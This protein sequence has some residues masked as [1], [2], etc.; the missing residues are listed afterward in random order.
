MAREFTDISDLLGKVNNLDA[1]TEIE[2]AGVPSEEVLTAE[3]F[4]SLV[5][6]LKE[7]QQEDANNVKSITYN[8]VLYEPDSEGNVS[9]N[10]MLNQDTYAVRLASDTDTDDNYIIKTGDDFNIALRYMAI[11]IT[12]AGDRLNYQSVAGTLTVES[13]TNGTDYT[14]LYTENGLVSQSEN[15]E[16]FPKA[17]NLGNYVQ[18]GNQTIKVKVS[19]YYLDENNVRHD[20][21]G[22]LFF[23]INAVNL[24][25]KNMSSWE[26][27]IL[28]SNEA[29]PLSMSF[30][31]AV[32]K[33]LHVNISGS[34]GTYK[35]VRRFGADVQRT[36]SNPYTWT[37]REQPTIGILSH[38]VHTVTAWLSC[39]DGS[40]S[41]DS[42]GYVNGIES[43][44][45]VNRF[46]VVNTSAQDQ[47]LYKPYLLLQQVVSTAK[48]Y[49]RTVL[50]EYAVW[51]PST[52]N[53]E[54]ASTER[55]PISIRITDSADNDTD[56]TQE[57]FRYETQVDSSTRYYLDTTVEIEGTTEGQAPDSYDAYLRV[58][59]Y[60]TDDSVINFMQES[61]GTRYYLIEI[62]NSDD[63]SPAAGAHFFL[64]PKVRN[65]S[66]TNWKRIINQASGQEVSSVWSE[67][68]R[69]VNDGWVED[70]DG[71]KVLRVLAGESLQ[72]G[73]EPW[74]QFKTTA[75][76][77]MSLEITFAVRNITNEEEPIFDICQTIGQAGQLL[78]LR[79]KPLTAFL[80]AQQRQAEN[81]QDWGF[82]EDVRT[83]VM[84]VLNPSVIA[85]SD[86]ELTW[87]NQNGPMS[88][89][90]LAKI[91]INGYVNREI[92]YPLNVGNW[93]QGEGHGGIKI[94][95]EHADIDIYGIRCYRG[96][97]L[98]AQTVVNQNFVAS[99]P[100]AEEKVYVRWANDILDGNGRIS[101]DKVKGKGKRCL[102]LFGTDN[103]KLNQDTKNGY[104]C[105]W[106]IDYYDANGNYIPELSGTICKSAYEAYL[107]GTLNGKKCLM[108]TAQGST[109]NTYWDNNEQTKLDKVTF[110]ISVLFINLHA[111][112]GW[113]ASMST[114][115]S[116]GNCDN[117]IYLDGEQITPSEYEGLTSAQKSRV[118]IDVLDGWIDGNGM[119]HGQ[120][121]TSA[122]G[123]AKAT[124]LVNKINYASPMQ[125]HK[126]GATRL[127]NDVMMAVTGGMALHSQD[128]KAR[129]S[130]LEDSFFFFTANPN[131][132]HKI[133]YRGL[134]TFGSGKADKPTW[135]YN[136]NK[137]AFMFEGANNNLPLCDFR[138]PAD[139][140]VVYVP[141]EEAW[142]Y[143]GDESFDYDLGKT[144]EVEENGETVEYPIAA[145]DRIFRR[146]V[147]F[148]YTHG[149]SIEMF[150]GSHAE[151]NAHFQALKDSTNPT[152]PSY[153]PTAADA[154]ATMKMKKYWFRDGGDKFH[155]VRFNFVTDSWVDAGRYDSSE[156][157]LY[158]AGVLDLSTDAMTKDAYDEWI[159]S[160]YNGDYVVLNTMFI[161]AIAKHANDNF[162]LVGHAKAHKTNYNVVNFLLAGTDNCSKNLYFH[163]DPNTGLVWFDGDDLDS[164]FKTDNNG[165]QTKVY[166]L[167]RIHDM[168]DYAHGYKRQIDYEGRNSN[169]FN[170]IEVMWEEMSDELRIN[171]RE[172]LTAMA[173]LVSD[174]DNFEV[175]GEK[176]SVW[177]CLHKYFF[178]I[179]RYFPQ[180]AYNEQARLRYEYPKSFGYVSQGNQA[181]GVDPITQSVGNQLES[182]TQYMKR[183]L[184]LVAS[185]ACWGD[186]SSGVNS[187]VVGLSDSGASFSVTPGSGRIG[188]DYEF[189]VVPH[190]FIYPTG[191][192]DRSAIDPHVR[193]APGE[194]YSIMVAE[195][196][197]ISGDSSVGL[198]ATN[199]YRS[200]G[201][202]GNMVV[203]NNSLS[204]KGRR[205]TEFIAEPISGNEASF[206]PLALSLSDA[207]N[208]VN[209]SLKGCAQLGG[210]MDFSRQTRLGS[211][212]LRG[213]A[214]DN[215]SL[216]QTSELESIK[217]G[218]EMANINID[219][220]PQLSELT[221]ESAANLNTLRVTDSPNVDTLS[222]V[223]M[224][225]NEDGELA[226][227]TINNINWSNVSPELLTWIANIPTTRLSGTMAVT[228]GQN[229]NSV[230]KA[231][232]I[233]KFGEIDSQEN[234]LYITYTQ[235]NATS[236]GIT[237][238]T[239]I[240]RSTGDYQFEYA[241]LPQAANNFR[242]AE[243]SVSSNTVGATIDA[244]TGVLHV[245]QLGSESEDTKVTVTLALT[246]LSGET[247]SASST[248]KLY[249]RL[250]K[251][252]DFAYADGQFDAELYFGKNV[253]GMVYK[254]TDY[255]NLTAA[256]RTRHFEEHPEWQTAYE[257]GQKLY[258][259][260][261]EYKENVSYKTS[262]EATT[263][264]ST[265]WGV[266][267][268]NANGL[269]EAERASIATAVTN[270]GS[271]MTT[272]QVSDIPTIVNNSTQGLPNQAGTGTE[273]Y[274]RD[275]S[276]Y[277]DNQND[278][279]KVYPS[280]SAPAD[281]N[282][283]QKTKLIVEHANK[284]ISAY[285]GDMVDGNG[286]TI[287]QELGNPDHIIP[288][289][290]TELA[291]LLVAL[292]NIGG[293]TQW[294]QVAYPAAYSCFLMEPDADDLHN[295]Y[296]RG[297]WYLPGA[298]DKVRLYIFF[299]NSRALT[300][301]DSG[302]PTADY[303][304]ENNV[305][306]EPEPTEARKP[307]Y[308]NVLK[309]AADKGLTCPI[310][311]PSLSGSWSSSEYDSTA[312]WAVNFND[313]GVFSGGAL[314]N[315][316]SFSYVVRPVAEF[317]FEL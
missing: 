149:T 96:I 136:T 288:Q 70:S 235:R 225:V 286:R 240:I 250:P 4:V 231:L 221:I 227:V 91:Y 55:L 269:T 32:E 285:V 175:D 290:N 7:L 134:S 100:S 315:Y 93:I 192:A 253:V 303:S 246:L 180:V 193:V 205:L 307:I 273:N 87:Q 316:K 298:A 51:I 48:N 37:E 109:A 201:N 144:V 266:F 183:R 42:D 213:T 191:M 120:C 211:L 8:N 99:L 15:S 6:A 122:I 208:M 295:Q 226:S 210:T 10:Q 142:C 214:I 159:D 187:G 282:G 21:Y 258:A 131:D 222:I 146:Y 184:A 248:V 176:K 152:S 171:M 114:P 76:A 202:V 43:D 39:D 119:Y 80:M 158:S 140:D 23:H 256:E 291:D 117:P 124:K 67:N 79:M 199:Y 173:G 147:N 289:N 185:Y 85:K 106:K 1:A 247:M 52:E 60:D 197:R 2:E 22:E 123:A 188:G 154:I 198:A 293:R 86:D 108:N 132:N 27:P 17:I 68:F 220:M 90:S 61:F 3:E 25:V 305:N 47:Y 274:V 53:P 299:R 194:H 88:P 125:S 129:F 72:I 309:R 264:S 212:D 38:G 238:Q 26:Q 40:G 181:R 118:T 133:E 82:Q 69:G 57:Y 101:Y 304:D 45:V 162:G 169:L 161:H 245:P 287:W 186:F 216:P 312:A 279:F 143:N 50:S 95:C 275:Y 128:S 113:S 255:D 272:A 270:A 233:R 252:G 139:D 44:R 111:D 151:F 182:E 36:E 296:K 127:F 62:D 195:S 41:V 268:N 196:G 121:Y 292:G 115:D 232:L 71:Q 265:P 104:A 207:P 164:I 280:N 308:A 160:E 130:V 20:I 306:R 267:S 145:N 168:E 84:I 219:G 310:A 224:A 9:F 260:L 301:A 302:T 278:G 241:V 277:D 65:N 153:D 283:K 77:Q 261:V 234:E 46:M 204:V 209:I 97:A 138:V 94:G 157:L 190:Q 170:L 172:V 228:T 141:S 237:T 59:R 137:A 14:V 56:Y 78:G 135:G 92:D 102:T 179:Q 34:Y 81:D 66:E 163:V 24:V 112:F 257:N 314:Y 63:F 74:E 239:F 217:F 30:T 230:L 294:R 284:I 110:V 297:C 311:M 89:L 177:G 64:N 29:F 167:D 165:R 243:W 262:D 75:T 107:A 126:M 73:Y 206:A 28:A 31:G 249:N 223:R 300:P 174:N 178:S 5:N 19:T 33:W 156:D 105:Y 166:F 58:F 83:H 263:F 13:S 271:A 54:I 98:S 313:G 203:G 35:I 11:H 18:T 49:V 215:V 244:D 189:D 254:V 16:S 148:I 103:Y 150:R 317:T 200:I 116:D 12:A 242:K 251:V 236:I 218:A 259:V 229:V 281:W 276:A 155:L